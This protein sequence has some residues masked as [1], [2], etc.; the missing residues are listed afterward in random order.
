MASHHSSTGN[1]A[2]LL[3]RA[4]AWFLDGIVVVVCTVALVLLFFALGFFPANP[5]EGVVG[6]FGLL[7]S[8]AYYA[9]TEAQMDA[10]L[11]K[12]ILGLRV[13]TVDGRPCTAGGAI[14]R[15]LTKVLGGSALFP[16]LVA[17]VFV[18]STEKNQRLGDLFGDTVVVHA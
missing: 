15:N 7:V 5:N 13:Q 3:L 8:M 17:I 2:G 12:Q 1:P 6:L 10:T 9:G 11:G 4:V 16:I 14:M 18:L